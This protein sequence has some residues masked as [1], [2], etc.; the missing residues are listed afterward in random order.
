MQAVDK[1][2]KYGDIE[3]YTREGLT[4]LLERPNTDHVEIF[5]PTE[6]NLKFKN[7]LRVKN[8]SYKK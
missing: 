1:N 3:P 5:T 2:G 4:K 8:K 6:E 7:N